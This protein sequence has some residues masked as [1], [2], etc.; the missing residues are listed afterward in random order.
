[1]RV[2]R[3]IGA[4]VMWLGSVLTVAAVAWFAIDS[5][6]QQV[7]AGPIFV[8]P[9]AADVR[10]GLPGD[11][12]PTLTPTAPPTTPPTTLGQA[13]TAQATTTGTGAP[14][15]SSG[16]PGTVAPTTAPQTTQPPYSA[17]PR[18]S[19][20]S[21][22]PSPS[23]T[24]QTPPTTGPT[25]SPPA[26]AIGDSVSTRGGRVDAVCTG[27]QV[28]DWRARPYNGWGASAVRAGAG[29]LE[30]VFSR[31]RYKVDVHVKCPGGR[32]SFAVDYSGGDE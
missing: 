8:A 12:V 4:T 28:T 16:T 10:V 26:R 7:V 24:R 23:R 11:E 14:A 18:P 17:G 3:L 19:S 13:V 29:E 25:T 31:D 1:M 20:T 22:S 27:W 5:A 21:P 15:S 2:S 32:P 9:V 6:G 30:V